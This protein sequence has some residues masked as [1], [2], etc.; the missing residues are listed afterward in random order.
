MK[1]ISGRN[2]VFLGRDVREL[3]PQWVSK[4]FRTLVKKAD[5][6][7][8]RLHDLRHTH[9]SHLLE[10]GANVKAVQERLGHAYPGFTMDTYVHLVPT[11]QA[12][13]VRVLRRFYR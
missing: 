1:A 10:A 9:A 2:Y 5:L 11:I 8:I 3:D 4:R 12:E 7:P 13:A 6:P